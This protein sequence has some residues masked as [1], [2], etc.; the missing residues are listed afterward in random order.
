MSCS[1]DEERRNVP[2]M[3]SGGPIRVAIVEDDSALREGLGVLIGGTPGFRLTGA[4]ESA[5]RAFAPLSKDGP[6]VLLLDINLPGMLGSQAAR[7]LRDQLPRT[8]IVM[9]T[10]YAE[11]DRVFESICNGACGYLLKTTPPARL[12]EAIREAHGGGSPMSPEIA[13]KVVSLFRKTQ[14]PADPGE[15]LTP[16]EVRLLKLLSEGHSY[17]SAGAEMRISVN[18]VRNY[19]R[20]VYEK[21]HVHSKSEA[22]TKALRSG[23]IS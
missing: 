22:V 20:T 18:T 6:D 2:S 15:K 5:E 8:Q 4:F 23:L 14:S 3:V 21:L 17:Q 7:V 19:I 11:Q 13:R 1:G 9:L 10:V 12:L 16:T